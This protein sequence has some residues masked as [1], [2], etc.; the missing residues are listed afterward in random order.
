[1]SAW[2]VRAGKGGTLA[3]E[4]LD[5]SYIAIYWNFGGADIAALNKDQLKELY[6]K[7][8]PEA[9]AQV[10]ASNV[11]MVYRFAHEINEGSTVITYD[12]SR[13]L[14]HLGQVTGPCTF[15]AD[16]NDDE[17][18]SYRRSVKWETE[19]SR[20]DLS[21]SAKHSLGSISTLFAVSDETLAELENA[22]KGIVVPGK[23]VDENEPTE[24]EERETTY[25]TGLELIKDRIAKL[26]WDQMED[27]VAGVLRAMGYKTFTT[28]RSNDRGR[29][30]VASPDGLGL[31]AP[32]IVAEVKH[33]KGQIGA[34][35]LRSFIGGL[36]DSDSGLYISTGGFTKD[37]M[38]EA[39][40]A[41]MPI[42]LLDLDQFARLYTEYYENTDIMTR[43]IL[44]LE[45]IYWPK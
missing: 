9:N 15:I 32:R 16:D 35:Q 36:L 19:I 43:V 23:D 25:E 14:Y 21:A 31:E 37:A 7:Y 8:Y 42:K 18:G 34:F 24:A 44:P 38:Y 13:R 28:A 1:M 20:D 4:W 6:A 12:P 41:P 30:V 22:A 45:R 33:R 26:D 10:I 27:L 11:G 29:D 3:D 2:I 5:G 17:R 40:R 39:E